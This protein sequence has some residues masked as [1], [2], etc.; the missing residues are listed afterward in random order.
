MQV[1]IKVQ[2]QY[3]ENY[4]V[5]A[6]GFNNYGDKPHFTGYVQSASNADT[7]PYKVNAW[8][9]ENGQIR[10]EIVEKK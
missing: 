3:F 5:D 10:L 7:K 1:K 2:A 6:D 9:N 8:L 4:N